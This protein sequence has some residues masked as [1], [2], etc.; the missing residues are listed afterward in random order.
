MATERMTMG[1]LH[2]W[3]CIVEAVSMYLLS[4]CF[5]DFRCFFRLFERNFSSLPSASSSLV[6]AVPVICAKD[7]LAP[8]ITSPKKSFTLSTTVLSSSFFGSWDQECY[9]SWLARMLRTCLLKMSSFAIK[10]AI[11]ILIW[12]QLM[13]RRTFPRHYILTLELLSSSMQ[14]IIK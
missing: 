6:S 10:D 14:I 4:L 9:F 2:K 13:L 8:A 5:D 12:M 7:S 11:S 1:F 3:C